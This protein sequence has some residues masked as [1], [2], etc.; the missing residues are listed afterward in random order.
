M[1]YGSYHEKTFYL[2]MQKTNAQISLT[3]VQ[4]DQSL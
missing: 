4:A 2:H 1:T 3:S